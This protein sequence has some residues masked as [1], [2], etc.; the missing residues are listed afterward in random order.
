MKKNWFFFLLIILLIIA[1]V[2]SLKY[3]AIENSWQEVRDSFLRFDTTN[4]THQLIYYLR[5][6]RT[7]ASLAVGAAFA[8]SGALM[9]GITHNPIADSGLLGINAGAGL[10]LALAFAFSTT[11]TPFVT[12]LSSF[13][14]AAIVLAV[15]YAASNRSI[16]ARSPIY[17]VLLGAA[18]GSF[19]T[20]L[21]QSIRLLFNLNQEITFW[22]VG[23]S[24]NVTWSQLKVALPVILVGLIGSW[25]IT[26]QVTLLEMGDETAVSLGKKPQRIREKSMLCVLL[27]AGTAVSLVGTISFLGLIVPHVVRFFVGHDYRFVIPAATLFGALFFVVADIGSRLFTPPLETPVG[28]IITLIGVPLLL[29]QI[30]RG[31]V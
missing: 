21:S 18:I 16:F 1:T 24:G 15:I 20:A 19:F 23:G 9:Q 30:R 28:V 2:S 22:F 25:L 4:Q 12:I 3:G 27:L 5:F 8:A 6:P 14:G 17:M 13:I 10:G 26:K 11:P 31:N 29:I 7:I